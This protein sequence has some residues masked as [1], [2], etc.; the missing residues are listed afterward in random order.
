MKILLVLLAIFLLFLAFF[1]I[2]RPK[3]GILA[4][5]FKPV[6]S[7]GRLPLCGRFMQSA[8]TNETDKKI[9]AYP[10]YTVPVN[11]LY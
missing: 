3:A 10:N 2:G 4:L 9:E 11:F 6:V 5:F 1:Y 8:S 7:A